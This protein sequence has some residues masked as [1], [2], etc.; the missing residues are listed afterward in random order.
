[1]RYLILPQNK[2]RGAVEMAR[3]EN[4]FMFQALQNGLAS[5]GYKLNTNVWK[6]IA[7]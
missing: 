4:A 7:L 1:M 3:I 2:R 5:I 6:E